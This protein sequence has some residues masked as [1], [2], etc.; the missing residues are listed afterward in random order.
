ECP[1]ESR[2]SVPVGS[3]GEQPVRRPLLDRLAAP[4]HQPG[5][6]DVECDTLQADLDRPP[7]HAPRA[8]RSL[9][10][11]LELALGGSPSSLASS[12]RSWRWASV[13]FSGVQT[14]TRMLKSPRPDC[15]SRGSPLPRSRSTVPLWVPA[16][17]ATRSFPWG[18]GMVT[19]VP[20]AAWEKDS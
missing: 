16:G 8:S 2:R 10:Q 6:H 19:V 5:G 18:V 14:A 9:L 7:A 15:P 3:V 13:R 4:A 20:N 11:K 1:A 12:A 17:M